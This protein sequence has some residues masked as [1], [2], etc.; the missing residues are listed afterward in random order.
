MSKRIGLIQ[1][2]GIGDIIIA[3]PIADFFIQQGYEVF[4]PIDEQFKPFFSQ[5]KPEINFISVKKGDGYFLETPKSILQQHDCQRIINLYSYL[6]SDG[7]FDKTSYKSLKFDEY[8]YAISGVPFSNKWNLKLCR[9][10]KRELELY[11]KLGI[12]KPY[13]CVHKNGTDFKADITIPNSV[14]DNYQIIEVDNITDN[15]F[16]WIYTFENAAK[17][18]FIDSCFS[19]LVEQLNLTNEKYLIL[20]SEVHLTPVMKNGWQFLR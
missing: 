13:I 17:L 8:K 7:V 2:R 4:W 20:R 12:T 11:N 15:P 14:S 16:D 10:Q 1:T 5:V 19:N 3:I 9:N 6:L 18:I